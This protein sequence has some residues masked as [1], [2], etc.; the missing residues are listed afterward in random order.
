MNR[1]RRL[2]SRVGIGARVP[3]PPLAQVSKSELAKYLPDNPVIIEAGAHTGVDT[4]ELALQWPYGTIH[5]FEPVPELFSQLERKTLGMPNVRLSKL[6][7]SDRS[8]PQVLHLSGGASDGSSSL[9]A[10]DHHLEVH[11]DVLFDQRIEVNAVTL[12]EW[13]EREAASSRVDFL[14]L[15]MQGIEPAVLRAAPKIL[16]QVRLVHT[17]VSLIPVYKNSVLYP[18][19]RG[20]MEEQGFVVAKEMLPFPD[21]GNVLFIRP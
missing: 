17:E 11:P 19:F 5:A 20:W 3:S 10:P 8:G 6:A 1:L 13:W 15:D 14:W 2:L 4:L 9:L 7:L 16:S 18:E 21:M 12:D